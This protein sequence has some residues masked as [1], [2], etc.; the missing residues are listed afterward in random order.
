M[1]TCS[2]RGGCTCKCNTWLTPAQCSYD[3][4]SCCHKCCCENVPA[5]PAGAKKGGSNAGT[6]VGVTFSMLAVLGFLAYYA[7]RQQ[8]PPPADDYDALSALK[9]EHDAD[10]SL[11]DNADDI[12]GTVHHTL[13][14]H[15]YIIH[16][17][18]YTHTLY[19]LYSHTTLPPLKTA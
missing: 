9:H 5:A 13:Y 19:T 3:D 4:G 8:S 14:T 12:E 15:Q 7:K 11:L 18:R 16:Y 1:A 2:E 6:G 17:T 10:A